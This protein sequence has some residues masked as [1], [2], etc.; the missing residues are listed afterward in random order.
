[1]EK[2]LF[3]QV[4]VLGRNGKICYKDSAVSDSDLNLLAKSYIKHYEFQN[5]KETYFNLA[6]FI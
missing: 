3:F 5:W 1:M 6:K 2:N 4:K